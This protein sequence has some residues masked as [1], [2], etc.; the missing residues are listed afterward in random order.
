MIPRPPRS[1]RTDTLFPYTTLFRSLMRTHLFV[2]LLGFTALAFQAQAQ[3]A[4]YVVAADH[5]FVPFAV[6]HTST[7]TTRGR[8]DTIT[9]TIQLRSAE[10][11]VGKGRVST[12][13]SWWPPSLSQ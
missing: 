11:R 1:T 8:F 5:R 7:S 4:A 6:V 9:G 3:N 13:R 12:G 2:T 10:R